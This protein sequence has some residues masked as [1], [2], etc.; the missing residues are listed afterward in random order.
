M[1]SSGLANIAP[2]QSGAG[3]QNKII[4]SLA[5]GSLTVVSSFSADA[6]GKIIIK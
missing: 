1:M 4:E 2:T 3:I 5:L 6:F